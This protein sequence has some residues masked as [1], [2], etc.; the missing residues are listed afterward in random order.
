MRLKTFALP[1]IPKTFIFSCVSGK[2]GKTDTYV[3]TNNYPVNLKT[4][5][6][7]YHYGHGRQWT[8]L[9]VLFHTL[10]QFVFHSQLWGLMTT[11]EYRICNNNQPNIKL[12]PSN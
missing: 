10:A 2:I 11:L 5:I 7:H 8:T 1:I 4:L 12:H 9:L 6:L 3:H